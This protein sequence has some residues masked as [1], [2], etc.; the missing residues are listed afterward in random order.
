MPNKIL[1]IDDAEDLLEL[2]RRLLE[3]RGYQVIPLLDGDQTLAVMRTEQPNLVILDMLMP[4]LTGDELCNAI[5]NEPDLKNIPVIITTGQFLEESS[6]P[7]D[8]KKADS[9]LRKP[10][11]PE[12]LLTQVRQ[13]LPV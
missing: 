2:T 6:H 13:F 5:K 8:F 12:D 9:Y 4:G 10:F 3:S 7:P 1:V 11:E